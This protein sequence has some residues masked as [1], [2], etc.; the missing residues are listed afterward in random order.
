MTEAERIANSLSYNSKSQL[1]GLQSMLAEEDMPTPANYSALDLSF[2]GMVP[3]HLYK[4]VHHRF[5]NELKKWTLQED[6][7]VLSKVKKHYMQ[8]RMSTS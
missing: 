5:T 2:I 3:D 7:I 8:R 6:M 4:H 1:M